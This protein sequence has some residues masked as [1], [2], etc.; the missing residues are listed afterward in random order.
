MTGT[1]TIAVG[2]WSWKKG[3]GLVPTYWE[4]TP[5]IQLV[6]RLDSGYGSASE[7][8]GQTNHSRI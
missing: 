7:E 4:W 3:Q 6:S 5:K 1:G 2:S 8:A